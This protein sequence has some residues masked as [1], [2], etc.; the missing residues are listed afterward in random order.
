MKE[1]AIFTAIAQNLKRLLKFLGQTGKR[2][3]NQG[4]VRPNWPNF[5]LFSVFRAFL[6]MESPWFS[7]IVDAM[8]I[9][10]G[11]PAIQIT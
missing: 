11:K 10:P 4:A 5:P 1:Q 9:H 2:V 6:P 7:R 8:S 3:P